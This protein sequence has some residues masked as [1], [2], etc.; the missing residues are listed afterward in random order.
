METVRTERKSA[1]SNL[2]ALQ[3]DYFAQMGVE[4]VVAT[5]QQQT[6]PQQTGTNNVYN[7]IS[8]PGQLL[9]AGTSG[10]PTQVVP[11]SSGS[12]S[13]SSTSLSYFK[14]PDFNIP[15]FRDPTSHLI[16]EDISDTTGTTIKMP[17]AWIYVRQDPSKGPFDTTSLTPDTTSSDAKSNPI[18]GRYAYWADDESSKINYN[19]AWG[20]TVSNTAPVGDISKIDLT[21]LKPIAGSSSDQRSPFLQD[22]ANTLHSFVSGNSKA[23]FN[24]PVDARQLGGSVSSALEAY[25]FEVTHY[26][27]DP[28]TTF[29]NEPRI[30]LTTQLANVPKKADGVIPALPFLDIL[31]NSTGD[32]GGVLLSGTVISPNSLID[33]DKLTTTLKLLNSYLQRMDWPM[34]QGKSFQD[35]FYAN[36]AQRL[37]QLSLN[38]IEYV[39]CKESVYSGTT[40]GIVVPLRGCWNSSGSTFVLTTVL[41]NAASLGISRAPC[42]TEMGVWVSATATTVGGVT[43]YP[44]KL[45]MEIYLPERYGISQIDINNTL[46]MFGTVYN[47][48]GLVGSIGDYPPDV[49][50]TSDSSNVTYLKAGKYVLLTSRVFNIKSDT[51]PSTSSN[52]TFRGGLALPAFGDQIS[53]STASG[54]RINICPT[55]GGYLPLIVDAATVA[56][57]SI[58]TY[59]VNDPRINGHVSDWTLSSGTNS[60]L[61][62]NSV[63][64]LKKPASSTITPQQD[65]DSDGN[66]TDASLYMPPPKGATYVTTSGTD[67]NSTG[68]MS[69]IGELG[70][71]CTGIMGAYP[72]VPWRSLRLQPNND[73]SVTPAVPDWALMDLFTV[74]V[75]SSS[76]IKAIT[77]PNGTSYA[78]RVNINSHIQPFDLERILPLAAVFQ[79]CKISST[80]SMV[81][82]SGTAQEIARSIYDRTLATGTN[83]GKLYSFLNGYYSPGEICEIKGVA[84]GGEASEELVR[85][86]SNLVTARGNVFT[87]YTIG[88]T[89][90][91]TPSGQLNVT[92]ER[93]LQSMVERYVYDASTGEVRFRTVLY[94]KLTP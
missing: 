13:A 9:V 77:Q 41:G 44:A 20:R 87:V 73:T 28:D 82:D 7:W 53:S 3:A 32:P 50:K 45:K 66:V 1:N 14:P 18:V 39:R 19:L 35:K 29:F 91:Q 24:T 74:P 60:F 30:V 69:S 65:T 8:Q 49:I 58:S 33:Q 51:R 4:R 72:G 79:G 83:A 48:S 26:N 90:K 25:K 6:A 31:K 76:N 56:E 21:A 17:I 88:Q 15:A 84:D 71:I 40:G 37:T 75:T 68:Q 80:N 78:G 94:K 64:S 11:L 93:R 61:K 10:I 27:S 55:F 43:Y 70:Y 38:I 46:R 36:N 23:F 86:A 2:V 63:S 12:A 89:V 92:G 52:F 67:D 62:E 54:D 34:A 16:S 47:S 5:L 57:D 59:E 85:Q 81:V 42:I 22:Y